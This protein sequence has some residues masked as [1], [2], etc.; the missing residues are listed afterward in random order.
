MHNLRF[1]ILVHS[2][3]PEI[4][5]PIHKEKS[6]VIYC[7]PP[8]QCCINCTRVFGVVKTMNL[9]RWRSHSHNPHG[10]VEVNR[11]RWHVSCFVPL[12]S[13]AQNVEHKNDHT[14]IEWRPNWYSLRGV[15]YIDCS[16]S[17]PFIYEKEERQHLNKVQS[18]AR[19]RGQSRLRVSNRLRSTWRAIYHK[20]FLYYPYLSV[21]CSSF[22]FCVCLIFWYVH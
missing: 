5:V 3:D 19:F 21:I 11:R 7:V 1:G 14:G 17:S 16:L 6:A 18:S 8:W 12:P 20:W 9:S 13:R 22:L 15:L 4:L 10:L 2:P